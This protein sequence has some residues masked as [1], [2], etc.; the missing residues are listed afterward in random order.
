MELTVDDVWQIAVR[1]A[2]DRELRRLARRDTLELVPKSTMDCYIKL[3]LHSVRNNQLVQVVVHQPRQTMLIFPCDQTFC[4]ILN[5]LQLVHDHAR[6][7]K[8]GCNR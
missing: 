8:H 5:V 3:L 2:G 7:S 1:D 6:K 4:I